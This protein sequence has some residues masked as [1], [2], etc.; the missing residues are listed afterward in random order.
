[1]KHTRPAAKVRRI[2]TTLGLALLSMGGAAIPSPAQVL[3]GNIWAHDPTMIEHQGCYYAFSTGH[4][5]VR[6]GTITIRRSCSGLA[7][8]WQEIGTVFDAQP[9]WI[10]RELGT[11]P[12]HLW[13][14]D[15]TYHNGRYYLYYAGS[16]F[17]S[18]VS[19]I[20]LATNVT[21]DPSDP[22]YAWID[23]GMV[24][25]SHRSD[26]FNAIDPDVIWG[27]DEAWL[28]FGSHWDGIKMRRLDPATGK[29]DANDRALY[30]LA[31]R[32]GGAIEA[33]SILYREGYYYLFVSF[34]RCC[35]GRDSTYNIRVGRSTRITGPYH[36]KEGRPMRAGGGTLLLGRGAAARIDGGTYE[37]RGA[38]GQDVF[39]DP[40]DNTWRLV[41]HWY[42]TT[43]AHRMSVS[44]IEW[45]E[46]G[47]PVLG[48]MR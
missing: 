37:V 1:M 29:P 48:P 19:V 39:F 20:G 25:R 15:I 8:P 28:V 32:G 44:D 9:A 45:T 43:G 14:P 2:L 33:P 31:S 21:L 12:Q 46:D 24:I 40:A 26:N 36:D 27:E 11:K 47:W 13:A 34:D 18:N 4:P 38:G 5:P 41:Y 6:E 7:G 16:T 10:A 23:E 3:T 17:G 42:T 35:A 22:A 30:S